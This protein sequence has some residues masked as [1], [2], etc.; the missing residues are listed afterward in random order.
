MKRKISLLCIVWLVMVSITVSGQTGYFTTGI[1]S[2]KMLFNPSQAGLKGTGDLHLILKTPMDNSQSGLAREMVFTG[3]IPVSESA[4]VGLVLQNQSAGLLKQTVFNFCYA[5]GVK[6]KENLNIRFGIGAGFKNVRA[7]TQN[8]SLGNIIGDPDDPA[9]TAY[10]S[11]PPSFYNVFSVSV[12]SKQLE[13]QLVAP[14]LTA[15]LQNK[16]LK[17]LDYVQLQGGV[18]YTKKMGGG[19][20]LNDESSLRVFAGAIKYKESGM[21]MMGGAELNANGYLTGSLMYNNNGV[22]TGGLGVI[23]EKSIQVGI[24]YSV[25]GLYSRAIYGGAG[26]AELHVGYLFKKK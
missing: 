24:N 8:A 1:F 22:L 17:S 3:D 15:S 9:L 21:I 10:N 4:G 14:N 25:G 16:N 7:Q 23:I 20:L 18:G 6:V 13:L 5:Y 26:V 11:I 19:N 2:S 12:T